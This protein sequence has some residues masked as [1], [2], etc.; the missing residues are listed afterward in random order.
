MKLSH[1]QKKSVLILGL[2]REGI[3]TYQILRWLFPKKQLTVAD[4]TFLKDFPK[5]VQKKLSSDRELKLDLGS[6]YLQGLENYEVII[7]TPGISPLL[8]E[9][10]NVLEDKKTVLTSQ[11]ELF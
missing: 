4:K 11:T 8:P 3:S 5:A 6:N 7:K 9:I 2:G 10:Q 1:L